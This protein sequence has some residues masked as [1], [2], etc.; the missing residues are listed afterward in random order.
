MKLIEPF[1]MQGI[2]LLRDIINKCGRPADGVR[3]AGIRHGSA[4][5]GLIA[6]IRGA[7]AAKELIL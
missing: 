4:S 3:S 6:G 2:L 5:G 1:C 7:F